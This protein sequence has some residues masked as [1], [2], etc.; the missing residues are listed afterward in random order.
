MSMRIS[1][2]KITETLNSCINNSDKR[3]CITRVLPLVIE[4]IYI[5][6]INLCKFIEVDDS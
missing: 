6:F 1:E 5:D 4:S 2:C 3:I